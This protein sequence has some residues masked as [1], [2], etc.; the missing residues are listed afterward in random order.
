MS[1]S[2][3]TLPT[4]MRAVEI[5]R[6]GGPEVLVPTTRPVPVQTHDQVL[7]RIHAA[8]V[9]GPDVLQRKGLY[10][11]PPGASDLPG[12]EIAGEVVAVGDAVTRFREGDM[13]C[14][15]VTG[16]GY[17]EFAAAHESNTLKIPRGLSV[18][19]AAGMPET[20]MTVWLNLFQRGKFIRGETVLIHGGVSG[21]GTTATM[22]AKAFGASKIITTVASADHQVASLRLGADL[23]VNYKEEDFVEEVM[24]FTDGVGVDVILDII[25]GDYVARNYQAA[26]MNGRI[27]QV[28]V[29]NGPARELDLFPMLT[30][31]LTHIGTTLRSRSAADKAAIIGEL[32]Q[33][34]W[35]FIVT[36]SIRPAVYQTFPLEEARAA[37]E[38]MDSALHVGKII[39]TTSAA[40]ML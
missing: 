5:T 10:D 11:P 23:A 28:S 13:V 9:N 29:I 38:L 25:A 27:L 2:L 24:R 20:F 1:H 26:A 18:I 31:R 4:K 39:L 8:G 33:N 17:S 3:R 35:P 22:M 34:V 36:G 30:K 12:L 16:S 21:V 37:H 40:V 19:E 15:L 6:P 14:A 7:I 32:E